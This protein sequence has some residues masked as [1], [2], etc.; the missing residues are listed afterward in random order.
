M[1]T[2]LP[3]TP[4]AV[5]LTVAAFLAAVNQHIHRRVA[6]LLA[7]AAAGYCVWAS[8][9]LMFRS[10]HAPIVY[11]MGGW[12]PR[13][14]SA[15]GIS[16]AI[17]PF[18]AGAG[19]FAAFLVLIALV[20]SAQ[21]FDSIGTIFHVL[22]L[23]FLAA[24]CGFS[25]TGDMFNLFVFFELMSAAAFALCG[26]KTEESGPI[27]GALN[28]AVTN[29]IGAFMALSGIG[30]L[31]GRTGALNMAQIGKSLGTTHDG[32]VV[33]A[34]VL[35]SCGFLVKAAVVPFHFWLADAHAVAPTPVCVLFSGVMVEL[36]L[37]AVARVYWTVFHASLAQFE[38]QTRAIFVTVGVITAI[39]GG[40]MCF[41]QRHLKRLLAYSTISHMGLLLIAF[42]LLAS[43]AAGG[44]TL[45]FFGHGFVKAALFIVAGILLNQFGSI[46]ELKLQGKGPQAFSAATLF[47]FLAL[48]LSGAPG[49]GTFMGEG[50]IDAAAE[51]L[52]YAWVSYIFMFSGIVTAGA[53]L[54]VGGRLY[55]GWGEGLDAS[56]QEQ[57]ETDEGRESSKEGVPLLMPLAALVLL[58]LGIAISF[59]P[60]IR[61]A[62][63]QAA[64]RFEDQAAYQAQV[65]WNGGL[66]QYQPEPAESLKPAI[67]R[68]L[69]ATVLAFLLAGYALFRKQLPLK[70]LDFAGALTKILKP[71][72]LLHSGSMCDYV[73]W[74]TFGVALLGGLFV[75]FIH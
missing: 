39:V 29:T 15:I 61:E 75:L 8:L 70:K 64:M 21:Y 3:A 43:K 52:R 28:F 18:G 51:K 57:G 37:Y 74:M 26:Y 34:F 48:G 17:D 35:I 25:L 33:T 7:I 44:L 58:L 42:A 41:S 53:V 56:Q 65:L 24:M 6:D 73:A 68:G 32:L 67:V 71:I 22:M 69:I 55:F 38:A 19:A 20:F 30:L 60:H 4:V 9:L 31:Y 11:W 1:N 62:V 23:A 36:G 16:F 46:D 47:L 63:E 54:R 13:N 50:M 45:Y 12:T 5:P 27:Q 66:P 14:A 10:I 72:R 59:V 40:L 2:V 49:Y